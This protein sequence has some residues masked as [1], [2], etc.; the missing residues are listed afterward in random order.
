MA[1][2]ALLVPALINLSLVM[3]ARWIYPH[4]EDMEVEAPD[5]RTEGLPRIFWLYLAG[6]ALVAAGFADF[7]LVAYHFTRASTVP[8]S[9]F[10][11]SMPLLWV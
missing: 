9:G 3:L 10:P 6:A 5:V 11:S 2:A 1:F 4:P 7:P 8:R